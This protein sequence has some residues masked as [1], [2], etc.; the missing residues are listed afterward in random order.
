MPTLIRFESLNPRAVIN[1]IAIGS[2]GSLLAHFVLSMVAALGLMVRGVPIE[3]ILPMLL[4]DVRLPGYCAIAGV[5]IVMS[6]GYITA[7]SVVVGPV[8]HAILAGV[9]TALIGCFTVLMWGSRLEANWLA[10]Q[11]MLQVLGAGLGGWLALPQFSSED[12][13]PIDRTAN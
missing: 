7:R 6:A 11:S 3:Q 8:R 13:Q 4:A 9:G 1:G 10:V 5:F 12:S 2:A